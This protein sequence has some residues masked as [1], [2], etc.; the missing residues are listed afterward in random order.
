MGLSAAQTFHRKFVDL[1]GKYVYMYPYSM[2]CTVSACKIFVRN[3]S[4]F[5]TSGYKLQL[6]LSWMLCNW[7]NC[8][9][10]CSQLAGCDD[11][12]WSHWSDISI[13]WSDITPLYRSATSC[14]NRAADTCTVNTERGRHNATVIMLGALYGLGTY[15]QQGDV[16]A[17]S[18]DV[19]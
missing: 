16:D 12:S 8:H 2:S 11:N 4:V 17:S 18:H 10:G 13:A 3:L 1:F 15:E 5:K 9:L 6:L 19:F 14:S 7:H